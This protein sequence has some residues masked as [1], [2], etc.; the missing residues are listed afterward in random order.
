MRSY[1]IAKRE[2]QTLINKYPSRYHMKESHNKEIEKM[3]Q[4]PAPYRPLPNG[5][6]T[7]ITVGTEPH[8]S[9]FGMQEKIT[10]IVET[11]ADWE[12]TQFVYIP[13][14][15]YK[16]V[17]AGI[18]AGIIAEDKLTNEW[19][20]LEGARFRVVVQNG[21]VVSMLPH[22]SVQEL[23]QTAQELAQAPPPSPV[24]PPVTS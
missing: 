18:V 20:V 12:S 6:C 22:E 13:H 9:R 11:P 10:C 4:M 2:A 23:V 21:K 14:D 1:E 16:K 19:Y 15:S 8:K 17:Q 3:P 5:I 24:M 7:L